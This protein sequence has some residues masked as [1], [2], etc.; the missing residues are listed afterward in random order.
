V[1]EFPLNDD[2]VYAATVRSLVQKGHLER[3]TYAEASHVAHALWGALF[4]VPAGCSYTALRLSTIVMGLAG[5]LAAF[6]LL[7]ECGA[8]RRVAGL[9][10]FMLAVNPLYLN[11]SLT[12]MTDVPFTAWSLG[13]ILFLARSLRRGGVFDLAVGS[14]LSLAAILTRQAGLVIPTGFLV[15]AF[16]ARGSMP[17]ASLRGVVPLLTGGA[18]LIVWHVWA[19]EGGLD[20]L[21]N[22]RVKELLASFSGGMTGVATAFSKRT[23]VAIAYVGLFTLPFL[24]RTATDTWR[25]GSPSARRGAQAVLSVL[26]LGCVALAAAGAW[27]PLSENMLYDLGVGPP[28]LWDV[29]IRDLPNLPQA[30]P[31]FWAAITVL[32]LIGGAFLAGAVAGAIATREWSPALV[33]VAATSA[34]YAALLVAAGFFDRYVI[35]LVPLAAVLASRIIKHETPPPRSAERKALW[36]GTALAAAYGLFGA[37]AAHDYFAWNRARWR[38]IEE[39]TLVRRVAT[40][41][42]DGGYEWNGLNRYSPTKPWWWADREPWVIAFGPVPGYAEVARYPYRRFLPPA[43]SALLLLHRADP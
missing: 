16:A 14:V 13:A 31:L 22:D 9:G 20:W 17:H 7:R 43:K 3:F 2:W 11:L 1:G 25:A 33:F 15:A 34:F 38:A 29:Y 10:A 40:S 41:S 39:A 42:L 12:F 21:S 4:C 37:A 30:P 26:G 5:I 18:G 27:M 19:K 6:A 23:F 35:L 8:D 28:T 32:A 24:F 36:A